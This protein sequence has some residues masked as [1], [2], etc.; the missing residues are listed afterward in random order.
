MT[1]NKVDPVVGSRSIILEALSFFVEIIF[2]SLNPGTKSLKNKADEAVVVG[3]AVFL[4]MDAVS[5]W[6]I[7]FVDS[8]RSQRSE[9][10]I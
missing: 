8:M 4:A 1:M 2:V 6:M 9:L 5:F 7:G 3:L 10:Y